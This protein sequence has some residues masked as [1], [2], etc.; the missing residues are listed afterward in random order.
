MREVYAIFLEKTLDFF[1]VK[2]YGKITKFSKESCKIK[3]EI[4][5]SE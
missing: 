5:D 1:Y 2:W 4:S 3:I